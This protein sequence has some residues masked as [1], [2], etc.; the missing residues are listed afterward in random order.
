MIAVAH[1]FIYVLNAVL[2]GQEMKGKSL[3]KGVFIITHYFC[4]CCTTLSVY[5]VCPFFKWA[6]RIKYLLGPHTVYSIWVTFKF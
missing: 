1:V 3:A 4:N 6:N 2:G 5:G